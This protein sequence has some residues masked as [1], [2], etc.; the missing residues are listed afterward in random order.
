MGGDLL[1]YL[2][3]IRQS[4]KDTIDEY[5]EG[6]GDANSLTIAA[7][8]NAQEDTMGVI[9]GEVSD[10]EIE[11]INH[12]CIPESIDCLLKEKE[13][14]TLRVSIF[15]GC[16]PI[17]LEDTTNTLNEGTMTHDHY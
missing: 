14:D 4:V 17:G 8:S 5:V 11:L 16:A 6:G 15:L 10:E 7:I 3:Y 13:Y 12:T 9:I 2:K 1:D